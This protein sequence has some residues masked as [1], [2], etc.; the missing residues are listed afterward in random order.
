MKLKFTILLQSDRKWLK[1]DPDWSKPRVKIPLTPSSPTRMVVPGEPLAPCALRVCVAL[2]PPDID[3]C[4]SGENLCQRN[5]DCI[6]IPGSYRC[7]CSTGYKLSPSG[8]CVGKMGA[9]CYL[10]QRQGREAR[11]PLPGLFTW[12]CRP[13]CADPR[14]DSVKDTPVPRVGC[15]SFVKPGDYDLGCAVIMG[16]LYFWNNSQGLWALEG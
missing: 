6:N 2:P 7:E 12:L 3:E 1:I 13:A 11:T 9:L 8:A 15:R 10:F 16:Y 5:A 4:S 14:R